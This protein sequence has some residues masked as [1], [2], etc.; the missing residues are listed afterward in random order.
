MKIELTDILIFIYLL[1]NITVFFLQREEIKQLKNIVTSVKNYVDIIDIK[2]VKEYADVR[3]E[4]IINKSKLLFMNDEKI[5]AMID[6][7]VN[8]MFDN[9]EQEYK[10]D[11]EKQHFELVDFA[12]ALLTQVEKR[13]RDDFI[14]QKLPNCKDLLNALFDE[15]DNNNS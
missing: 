14:R 4:T 9:L 15:I 5:Q 6:D 10:E 1:V 7:K 13:E 11:I 2:K 8:E 12:T 3:E